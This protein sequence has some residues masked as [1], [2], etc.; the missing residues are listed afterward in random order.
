LSLAG[1]IEFENQRLK[2]QNERASGRLRSGGM[3]LKS[4]TKLV[5]SLVIGFASL[6][7]A[8]AQD[9]SLDQQLLDDL[10]PAPAKTR[11]AEKPAD[12][13]TDKSATKDKL[14]EALKRDLGGEDI[15][16]E[17]KEEHPLQK[18]GR[19]MLEVKQRIA[20]KDTAAGTQQKQK[21]I[22]EEIA[23]L[24]EQAQ[25]KPQGNKSQNGNQ[26]KQGSGS[27]QSGADSG[28]AQSKPGQESTQ[29]LEQSEQTQTQMN[30]MKEALRR[31]WGHLPEKEREEMIGSLGEQFLPKYER[32]IEAFYKRLAE[33]PAAR[34]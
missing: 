34:P 29:R 1:K 5:L 19:E 15:G 28:S 22:A 14:D 30:E 8:V 25:K 12:P 33:R 27:T 23:K 26:N 13:K 18:L 16:Q 10:K 21:E 7:S 32:L 24:I 31:I 3:N 6:S 2:W 9:K 20:A 11:T 4:I 17:K